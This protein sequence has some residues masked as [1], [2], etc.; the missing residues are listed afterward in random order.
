MKIYFLQFNEKTSPIVRG[1]IMPQ[2]MAFEY[3]KE[4]GCIDD[5]F[6]VEDTSNVNNQR[7]FYTGTKTITYKFEFP[8]RINRYLNWKFRRRVLLNSISDYIITNHFTHIYIRRPNVVDAVFINFLRQLKDHNVRVI[9]D[10]PT[11]PYDD[12]LP[13]EKLKIDKKYRPELQKYVDLIASPSPIVEGDKIFG[14]P[15][16]D[17]PNGVIVDNIKE[18]EGEKYSDNTISAIAVAG[19]SRWHGYDRFIEGLNNYYESGSKRNIVLNIVGGSDKSPVYQE[20]KNLIEK[21]NLKNHVILH[22]AK[23]GPELDAIYDKCNIGIASLAFHRTNVYSSSALKTRE[24]LAKGLPIYA[25]TRIDIH[26]ENGEFI[27]YC[28]EDDSPIF[29]DDFIKFYDSVYS[30][31][32]TY[33]EVHNKIRNF[34]RETCDIRELMRPLIEKLASM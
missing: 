20:Y 17:V 4:I 2:K 15:Y 14:I 21:Y 33:K 24:Y 13:P 28:K 26:P 25:S 31:A 12:E 3:F 1:K 18:C 23:F 30:G 27:H 34:A 16:I 32:D 6:L 19:L 29:I 10:I 11:Y 22:G 7:E 8:N 5:F 9:Y